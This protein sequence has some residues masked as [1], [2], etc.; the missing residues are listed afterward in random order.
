MLPPSVVIKPS[1]SGGGRAGAL[2]WRGAGER[3]MNAISV[4]IVFEFSQFA[5][6]VHRV[7]E[8]H[9]IQVLTPDRADQPFNEGVGDRSVR[10]RLDF[11]DLEHA[12]VGEPAVESKQ[13]VVVGADVFR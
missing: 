10:N 2:R 5:L 11:L 9:P 1:K 4:V 6:Q 7:P 3:A 13:R 12:Q 8:K